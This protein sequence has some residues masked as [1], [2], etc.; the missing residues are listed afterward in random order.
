MRDRFATKKTSAAVS[1][2]Q[3]NDAKLCSDNYG[4]KATTPAQQA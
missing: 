1:V 2:Q 4:E 3:E